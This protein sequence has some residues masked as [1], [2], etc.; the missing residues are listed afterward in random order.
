VTFDKR[1]PYVDNREANRTNSQ[2][3]YRVADLTNPILTPLGGRAV[4]EGQRLGAGRKVP[5]RAR[6]RLLSVGRSELGGLHAR[7]ADPHP[8]DADPR[9]VINEAAKKC[10]ASGSTCRMR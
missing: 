1:Y 6:E 4:E 7:P 5:F 9:H 10:G 2:P 8:P 3:T